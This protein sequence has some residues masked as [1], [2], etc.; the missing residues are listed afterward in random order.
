MLWP[1]PELPETAILPEYKATPDLPE[2]AE[3]QDHQ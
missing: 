3:M 2:P 1:L